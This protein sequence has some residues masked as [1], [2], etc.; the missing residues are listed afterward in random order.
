M[1]PG[2]VAS[3][4]LNPFVSS[5]N[6]ASAGQ[7]N[8]A[9]L[10]PLSQNPMAA[11][12]AKKAYVGSLPNEVTEVFLIC[13]HIRKNSRTF[14]INRWL[15]V[16]TRYLEKIVF[17]R[18]NSSQRRILRMLR[19]HI[20]IISVQRSWRSYKFNGVGWNPI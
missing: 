14:L 19:Y 6:L 11:R 4:T 7:I 9:F 20:N 2:A 13:N 16:D 10:A 8:Q 1:L 17:F 3:G 12:S 15:T 5:F 18:L